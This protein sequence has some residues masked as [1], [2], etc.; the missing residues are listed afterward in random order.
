M[1]AIPHRV[2]VLMGLDATVFPRAGVRPGFHLMEQQRRLGDPNP[3]DQDRYVLLETL[4]SARSHLLITWNCRDDR[5]GEKLLPAAPVRQWL[6]WLDAGLAQGAQD[7]AHHPAE[8]RIGSL[9]VEHAASPLER[10]NFL[11]RQGRPP[12]SCDR[13]QL[14]ARRQLDRPEAEGAR[15]L[16]LRPMPAAAGRGATPMA[17]PFDDLRAWLMNPQRQWLRDLGLRPSEWERNLEDLEA[18]SLGERERSGLLRTFENEA[19]P[20]APEADWL[21]R[22]RGQG[23][24]PPGSAAA[25]E[26]R[27]LDT[28]RRDLQ[29]Q[30]EALGLPW[31]GEVVWGPWRSAQRWQGDTVLVVHW[32]KGNPIQLLDL[33]LQ[34]VLAAAAGPSHGC[35]PG[36]GVLL[37]REKGDR[38]G[39]TTLIAPDAATAQRELE[40]LAALRERWRQMCWPVPPRTGWRWWEQE[41]EGASGL[42]AARKEWE[43][44]HQLRGER[45]R[46]EMEACFGGEHPVE[47]LLEGSFAALAEELFQPIQAALEEKTTTRGK[48]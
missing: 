34:V 21:E 11:P 26:A 28:R 38:I 13:R 23:I 4:L 3:A 8:H 22:C 31:R 29:N 27:R 18:L 5:R 43:G 44:A 19:Q 42:A 12:A 37:A 33:W 6:D 25:L 2:V 36:R 24:L 9:L 30:A 32:A 7:P 48:R 20:H 40:R 1:R 17:E 47:A 35:L 10:T 16:L 14:A 46:P 41:R 15:P 39:A 45:E